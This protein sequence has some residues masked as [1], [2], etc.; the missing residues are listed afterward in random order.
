M[1]REFKKTSEMVGLVEINQTERSEVTGG[2]LLVNGP[3][4]AI[5]SVAILLEFPISNKFPDP[6]PM[7]M[8]APVMA[9]D[10]T[11]MSSIL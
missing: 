6:L 7:P 10:I 4:G 2:N 5:P 9:P 1:N 11:S 8:P 3:A